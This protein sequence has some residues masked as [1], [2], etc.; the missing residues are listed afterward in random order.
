MSALP[1]DPQ[2]EPTEPTEPEPT[3]PE[4]EPDTPLEGPEPEPEPTEPEAL[5]E[6]EIGK[7]IDALER[8][9][10]R[11]AKRVSEILQEEALDL[12]VCEACEVAIPGFHYPAA[13][14]PADSSQRALY[15]LLGGGAEAQFMHPSLYVICETCNG[16][17]QVLTGARNDLNRL[18]ACPDCGTAGYHDRNAQRPNVVAL[19]QPQPPGQPS[20]QP[21]PQTVDVD[22]LQRPRGHPNFGLMTT[23]MTP[24]QLELDRR[25]GYGL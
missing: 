21:Q 24:E 16:H 18:K 17:G 9:K 14:Y 10:E 3:E 15:E 22:F 23:Y 25:D 12:V 2:P 4:P 8:E 6:K 5:T 7:R 1:E 13:M 19:P 20:E 11:H